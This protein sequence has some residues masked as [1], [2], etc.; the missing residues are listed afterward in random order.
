MTF[1]PENPPN[2]PINPVAIADQST[3]LSLESF[4][5]D[6]MIPVPL[7]E[8]LEVQAMLDAAV[9]SLESGKKKLFIKTN[10]IN[11]EKT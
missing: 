6:G 4:F 3:N 8:T 10:R 1:F 7:E 5:I 9:K 11:Y 2:N